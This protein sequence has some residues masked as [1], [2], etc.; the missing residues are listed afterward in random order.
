MELPPLADQ[1]VT[2]SIYSE[3]LSRKFLQRGDYHQYDDWK[4]T[5]QA[6]FD[7]FNLMQIKES[8]SSV[9]FDLS[10]HNRKIP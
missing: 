8:D 6:T 1:T 7:Q 4:E 2:K 10:K 5:M 3:L 9:N